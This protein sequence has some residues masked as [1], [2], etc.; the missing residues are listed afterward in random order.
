MKTSISK[1]DFYFEKVYAGH[2]KVTYTS[3]VTGKQWKALITDM[4]LTDAVK[5]EDEPKVKDLNNLKR[6]VKY[7]AKRQY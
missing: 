6:I 1:Y 2:Y 5:Y 7:K 3:P 4:T